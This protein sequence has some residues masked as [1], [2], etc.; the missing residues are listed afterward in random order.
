MS[1]KSESFID[2]GVFS[3]AQRSVRVFIVAWL[4]ALMSVVGDYRESGADDL[5]QFIVPGHEREM[6]ALNALHALHHPNAFTNCTLWDPW[7]PHATLWTGP[8]AKDRYRD[9]FLKRRIDDEGYVSMQQHRGMAHSE[10][11]PFPAWQQGNGMGW[12]FSTLHEVW[13]VQHFNLQAQA[14]TDGWRIDGAEVEEIDPA[15]GLKLRATGDVVTIDTP[16]FRCGTI[17]APFVRIEWAAQGL[18]PDSQPAVSWLLEGETQWQPERR[19]PFA[20]LSDADGMRYANVPLYRQSDYAG[21]VTRYRLTFDQAESARLTLKS[22]ITAVDTRHPITNSIYLR[23]CAD[24][25]AWTGDVDFLRANMGRMRRALRFAL[26]EFSV[27]EVKHVRVPWV[28][29]DGRSGLV[30][31]ADG[32]KTV[33]HGLGVGNNY[34]DLLPF[35]GHDALATIYLFDALHHVAAL[36][37]EI[38]AHDPWAIPRDEEPF[39]AEDLA[40]LAEQV[41]RDFRER[42]WNADN[43]RF[44]GWI[45]LEGRPYDYGFTFVNLEAIYYGLASPE[46][47]RSIFDWLDGRREI[48]EDTSRGADI[49]HWRFAPRATTRRNIETYNWPWHAP[50]SIP[51][52]YQV[53]DGGAVLG[54]S[55]H[56]LMARLATNGPDDAWRRLREILAWFD[57]VQQEGGYRAY[58]ANPERGTLQG[59]GPPGGL[60]MDQEFLESV[61]VPQVMLYGFLG[62]QANADGFTLHPRLPDDWPSLTVTGVHY[63]NFV[64]DI[65]AHAGGQVKVRQRPS[66]SLPATTDFMS[67]GR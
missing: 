18:S 38:A 45:D 17:L 52:G 14:T 61:L 40:Q 9:S 47:A 23:G 6:E 51:W 48:A 60:G 20:P 43:G 50:E 26:D 28:G 49:Y 41:G 11:W 5:P 62:F 13:A 64:F 2:V 33:R 65:T 25:F 16:A 55:Y 27:R 59:G 21:I 35:G 36:E 3:R 67:V 57:E 42:F 37:R 1:G 22:V 56:D 31:S 7:L 15:S 30:V 53:Q 10:G 8:R 66:S 54:F 29:H 34:W 63:R 44:V 19:V 4:A 12:H 39:A 58:Y 24:Y 32:E 46:Q